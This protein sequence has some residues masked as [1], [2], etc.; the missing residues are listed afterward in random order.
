[1]WSLDSC[2]PQIERRANNYVQ[3]LYQV[4][5]TRVVKIDVMSNVM[6]NFAQY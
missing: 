2:S 3:V 6:S 5:G 1:M 4:E